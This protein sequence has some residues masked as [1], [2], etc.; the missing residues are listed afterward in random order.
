MAP[1]TRGFRKERVTMEGAAVRSITY[2]DSLAEVTL[3]VSEVAK[4]LYSAG[5]VT[6]TLASV[7]E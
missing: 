4:N 6:E 1:R 7:V 3:Y 5:S 2:R